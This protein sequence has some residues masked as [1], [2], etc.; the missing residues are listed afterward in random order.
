MNEPGKNKPNG[1]AYKKGDIIGQKYEVHDVLGK[2]GCGIVYLV[3]CHET[4]QVFALKTF[5]DEYIKDDSVRERFKREAQV[6]VNLDRHPY[7]VRAHVVVD[8]SGRLYIALEYIPPN[9][10]GCNTVED[11]L[12]RRPPDLAQSLRWAIEFSFGM[13]Y[14]YSKGIR[15]H[16]DIKPA[17]IMIDQNMVVKISDFGLAGILSLSNPGSVDINKFQRG[18]ATLPVQTA[19][20]TGFGTPTHMAPEQ[21]INAAG[22][23][24]R[25]DIYGFGIVLYQMASGGKLPFY[26]D[27]QSQ[28]WRVMQNLHNE[29]PV[30][31]LNSPLFPIIQ[32]CLQ[33]DPGRRHSSFKELRSKLEPLL[34][35]QTGE[36]IRPPASKTLE[37]WE[38]GNKGVSFLSLS[39]HEE[40]MGCFDRGLKIDP[41]DPRM[42]KN[43][44]KALIN[45][46]RYEEAL[47]CYD[48]ALELDPQHPSAWIAWHAK[49]LLVHMLKSDDEEALH[50][51]DKVIDLNPRY[52]EAWR[53]KGLF[54]CSL[55][56][57]EEALRCLDN[58]LELDPQHSDAWMAWLLK[59]GILRTLKRF[60]EAIH[61]FDKVIDLNP[62]D[63]KVWHEKGLVLGSLGRIE[64]ALH[65]YD[66]A[67]E[68]DP[69]SPEFWSCKGKTLI[70]LHRYEEALHCYDKALELNPQ[71]ADYWNAKGAIL[72]CLGRFEEAIHCH[73]KGI[74]LNPR[75][76]KGW[77]GK[78]LILSDL[79]RI[80]E[81]LH[82]CDKA[83]ELDPGTPKFW[84]WKGITLIHL[85]RF[86]EAL[87]CYD[88]A[89]ELDP[90]SPEFWNSKGSALYHLNRCEEAL[91]CY[92][93]VLGLNPKDAIAWN[94]KGLILYE[95][96]SLEEAICCFDKS[97]KLDSQNI[98]AWGAKGLILYNKGSFEEAIRCYD[99]ILELSPQGT[100]ACAWY[101]KGLSLD[102]LNR[103]DAAIHCY[104]KTLDDNPKYV[105]AWYSKALAEERQKM[106]KEAAQSYNQFISQA[107]IQSFEENYAKQIEYSRKRLREL[108]ETSN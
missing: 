34:K 52:A 31:K 108:E 59:G 2:G 50:C 103:C 57:I 45:L 83:L 92:D 11:Y 81:A 27:N 73:D 71:D 36:V 80:E 74:N 86:E 68:L 93:K 72:R 89:L 6:W 95:K 43:K 107:A 32:D 90:A 35:S 26:T 41:K 15:A 78:G 98:G 49:G 61:C 87:R 67:L 3:Y 13:E 24:E 88:K 91:R 1:F 48:K 7:L 5:R 39:H 21:F 47:R 9:E 105:I 16:R 25:S 85:H 23:D 66:K 28:F 51:F 12:R 100:D 79:R 76:A 75:N 62:R 56:R 63:V 17:N 77:F 70:D 30:P 22:C 20:G 102:S 82:C 96:G 106:G 33:K 10:M 97:L 64:E 54:L 44:G 53:E 84:H 42:W 46:N 69:G 19:I 60:E 99:K 29:A 4:K 101:N 55:G 37:A 38:W 8:I 58:A 14:A 40:A 65:C 18:G 104:K 94:A